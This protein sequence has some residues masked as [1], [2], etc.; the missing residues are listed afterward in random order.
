MVQLLREEGLLYEVG[1]LVCRST[2]P[3]KR[4]LRVSEKLV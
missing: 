4:D 2:R 1:V 3:V